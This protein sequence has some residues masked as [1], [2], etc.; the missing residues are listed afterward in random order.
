MGGVSKGKPLGDPLACCELGTAETQAQIRLGSFVRVSR[1]WFKRDQTLLFRYILGALRDTV[2]L[3]IT[4]TYTL[5][6]QNS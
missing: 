2:C 5:K 6:I 3:L 1:V 4:G